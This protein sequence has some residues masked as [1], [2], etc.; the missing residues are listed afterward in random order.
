MSR[1]ALWLE[2]DGTRFAGVQRL[3]PRAEGPVLT[4]NPQRWP[5]QETVQEELEVKLTLLLRQPIAVR[6]AGRTD[7]G[8]H[9]TDQ[10]ASF[11]YQ[12]PLDCVKLLRSLNTV[13]CKTL[14]VLRL[15]PVADDF[16]PRF[17][18][19][20]RVY[21]YYLWPAAPA[22]NSPFWSRM[23]W[24]VAEPL[25]VEAM[26]QAVQPLLGHHDFSAFSRRSD[27]S[28]SKVRDLREVRFLPGY[29]TS[30]TPVGPFAQ[31]SD[32]LCIEVR[33]NAFLRRMVRQLVANLVQVGRGV[34][35]PGRLEQILASGDAN[36]GVTPAPP[37]G[38]FLVSVDYR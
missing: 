4:G 35:E 6:L 21:H 13:L 18:A 38:L 37:Q 25:D 10:V 2:Y 16:H 5:A 32:L 17:S 31:L 12:L 24:L 19:R 8:V 11:D 9:A 26:R 28:E 22:H 29:L 33:A 34:W 30:S 36:L 3:T 23:C 7:A 1:Y 15:Q 27:P 14:R 20:E